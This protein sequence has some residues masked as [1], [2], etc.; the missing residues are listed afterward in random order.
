MC[1]KVPLMGCNVSYESNIYQNKSENTYL[2]TFRTSCHS[3]GRI[4]NRKILPLSGFEPP[5]LGA[6]IENRTTEHQCQQ[7]RD[8]MTT[9]FTTPL[10]S[11]FTSSS[12]NKEGDTFNFN[13]INVLSTEFCDRS[14]KKI[15]SGTSVC[16]LYFG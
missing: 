12:I 1:D 10:R 6:R 3:E 5:N 2:P 8:I 7:H 16:Q 13:S 11:Y 14:E 4:F 15:A 9:S